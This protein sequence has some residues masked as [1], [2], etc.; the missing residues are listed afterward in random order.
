MPRVG[1]CDAGEGA[2]LRRLLVWN[3]TGFSLQPDPEHFQNLTELLEVSRVNPAPTVM[4][5]NHSAKR[6]RPCTRYAL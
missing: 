2:V 6:G 4:R 1:P 3:E 5:W